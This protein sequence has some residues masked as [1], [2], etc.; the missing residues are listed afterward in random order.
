MLQQIKRLVLTTDKC[1]VVA[2][3]TLW[4]HWHLQTTVPPPY[5][6]YCRHRGSEYLC[7]SLKQSKCL[8]HLKNIHNIAGRFLEVYHQNIWVYSSFWDNYFNRIY[9][10]RSLN[11]FDQFQLAICVSSFN[12]FDNPTFLQI[13]MPILWPHW[14]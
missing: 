11:P 8:I 4:L 1:N 7:Q 9:K 3:I 2:V 14:C 6:D 5:C 10:M 12:L 13:C